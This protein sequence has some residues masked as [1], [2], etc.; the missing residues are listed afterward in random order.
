[1]AMLLL[2]IEFSNNGAIILLKLSLRSI[3]PVWTTQFLF[4]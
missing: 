2:S 3:R 4:L 1:M